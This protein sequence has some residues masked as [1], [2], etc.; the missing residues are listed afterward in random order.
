MGFYAPGVV[1]LDGVRNSP[2][3]LAGSE[4]LSRAIGLNQTNRDE[5]PGWVEYPD[6]YCCYLIR[7]AGERNHV[8]AEHGMG[9]E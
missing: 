7:V 5:K 3:A 6:C 4:N 9:G 8:K 1:S 2:V